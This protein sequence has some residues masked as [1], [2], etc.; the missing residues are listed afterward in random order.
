MKERNRR[1]WVWL[2]LFPVLLG[3]IIYLFTPGYVKLKKYIDQ[4]VHLEE[5]VEN[6]ERENRTL[7]REIE[8]LK[9]DPIYIERLARKELGMIRPGEV[10]YRIEEE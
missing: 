4:M 6:L 3:F 10:I 1:N 9:T 7:K 2:F 8:Q 5:R